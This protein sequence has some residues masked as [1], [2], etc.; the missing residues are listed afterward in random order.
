MAL[1]IRI[2]EPSRN[3]RTLARL[4]RAAGHGR[5]AMRHAWFELGKDLR[6]EASRE[7]LHGIKT[8]R[9]YIIRGPSGR[10]RRHRASAPGETHANRTGALRRG[11]SWKVHG[12]RRMEFGYGITP[13]DR[14]PV[15]ASF[16]ELG[17]RR[18]AARPTLAN[19]INALQ[20]NVARDFATAMDRVQAAA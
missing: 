10:R 7:V 3:T 1:E 6:A 14:S 8:G 16:V 18:M 15:Y 5:R 2:R 11:L 4:E 19:A 13:S 17:T 12:H 9:V 20:R